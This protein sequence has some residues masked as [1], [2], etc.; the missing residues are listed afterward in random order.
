MSTSYPTTINPVSRM[1]TLSRQFQRRGSR[2]SYVNLEALADGEDVVDWIKR[3]PF[4][5]NLLRIAEDAPLWDPAKAGV[6][7]TEEAAEDSVAVSLEDFYSYMLMPHYIFA[8]TGDLWPR[9]RVDARIPPVQIGTGKI[10]ATTWLDQNRPVEQL[11][12]MPG[13]PVIIE[14]QF[15][16]AGGFIARKGARVFNQYRPP[17]LRYGDASKAG[18]W[19]DHVRKVYPDQADHIIK[20]LAQRVQRPWGEDQSRARAGRQTG[21]RQGHAASNR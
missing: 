8:P 1:P 19:I 21:C 14:D 13:R 5:E 4:P 9:S 18:P 2:G 17:T 16:A 6:P 10:S 15:I 3:D 11:T 20:W 7:P 12:W